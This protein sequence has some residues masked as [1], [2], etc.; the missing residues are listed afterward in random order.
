MNSYL[1]LFVGQLGRLRGAEAGARAGH[2]QA[3]GP[4]GQGDPRRRGGAPAPRPREPEV[5]GSPGIVIE[6]TNE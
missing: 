4:G 1:I 3:R 6:D 2:Q 5:R